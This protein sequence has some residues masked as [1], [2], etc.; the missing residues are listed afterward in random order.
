MHCPH[1][2]ILGDGDSRHKQAAPGALWLGE[3][4]AFRADIPTRRNDKSA[5]WAYNKLRIRRFAAADSRRRL[6][7]V[8]QISK[9]FT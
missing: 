1:K 3:I 2:S 7:H 6:F 4:G 5:L 9:C 8:K